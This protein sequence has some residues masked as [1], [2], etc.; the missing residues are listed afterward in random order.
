MRIA[1]FALVLAAC[2]GGSKTPPTTTTTTT[3][4]PPGG[5]SSTPGATQACDGE[6]GMTKW[7]ATANEC[8]LYPGGPY[9]KAGCSER[10]TEVPDG[11]KCFTGTKWDGHCDCACETG[12]WHAEMSHCM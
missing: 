4:P 2:S 10:T 12:A 6:G 8:R 7:D 9:G 11:Q 5:G 1:L 3:T